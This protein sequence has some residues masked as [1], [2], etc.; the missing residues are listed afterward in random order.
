MS[1]RLPAEKVKRIRQLA[2]AGTSISQIATATGVNKTTVYRYRSGA[3]VRRTA[4]SRPSK[5][6]RLHPKRCAPRWCA[7][8]RASVT[9]WPCVACWARST[10][11]LDR[12]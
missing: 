10:C 6:D 9:F 3:P 12:N 1:R 11:N 2:A 4:T 8:C 5:A 7:T